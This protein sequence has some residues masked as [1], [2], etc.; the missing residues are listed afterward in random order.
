MNPWRLQ[1]TFECALEP[2]Q[3]S[4]SWNDPSKSACLFS[5]FLFFLAIHTRDEKDSPI[6]INESMLHVW[7][8]QFFWFYW[9][10]SNDDISLWNTPNPCVKRRSLIF[11]PSSLFVTAP[12]GEHVV[13]WCQLWCGWQRFWSNSGKNH[14][15]IRRG[16]RWMA[17]G[18]A[19]RFSPFW[20]V[21]LLRTFDVRI[22]LFHCFFWCVS[23]PFLDGCFGFWMGVFRSPPKKWGNDRIW[24]HHFVIFCFW[25]KSPTRCLC[26][27][28]LND[29]KKILRMIK[30]IPVQWIPS[31]NVS[32]SNML[33]GSSDT[34]GNISLT[35][36]VW[37]ICIYLFRYLHLAYVYGKCR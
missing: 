21:L 32:P 9:W 34:N 4:L 6:I 15:D 29:T 19:G 28:L 26:L 37:H 14:R 11:S 17:C 35:I 31:K 20:S 25:L 30:Q 7:L 33:L 23:Y 8:G 24:L 10:N 18:W 22:G 2:L 13:G 16:L 1:F 3:V 27:K 36:H 12:L 5:S